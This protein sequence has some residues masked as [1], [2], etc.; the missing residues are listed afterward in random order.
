MHEA[1][2]SALNA[3]HQHD[4]SGIRLPSA[5]A[6]D[7][8]KLQIRHGTGALAATSTPVVWTPI[9]D[10]P[11]I[12]R[13]SGHRVG[14]WV[15]GERFRPVSPGG[16][17]DTPCVSGE[18]LAVQCQLAS[19]LFQIPGPGHSFGHGC[20]ARPEPVGLQPILRSTAPCGCKTSTDMEVRRLLHAH[21]A[22]QSAALRRVMRANTSSPPIPARA[23]ARNPGRQ[24]RPAVFRESVDQQSG[25]RVVASRVSIV[26]MINR[27]R[28]L[29]TVRF[30]MLLTQVRGG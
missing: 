4:C 5:Q 6:S 25:L 26:G 7:V 13:G 14:G 22:R 28:F 17:T 10:I 15:A 8:G 3:A 1:S 30:R 24:S 9:T 29:V 12:W 2:S 21:R 16:G 20:R 18:R 11:S 19:C 27:P 23:D